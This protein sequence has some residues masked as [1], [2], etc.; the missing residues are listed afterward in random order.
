M[1]PLKKIPTWLII[2][3]LILLLIVIYNLYLVMS[4]KEGFVSNGGALNE[5]FD[6]SNA[7]IDASGI[8]LLPNHYYIKGSGK[9][10][11][12]EQ[13]SSSPMTNKLKKVIIFDRNVGVNST[14]Y[15]T[16]STDNTITDTMTKISVGYNQNN[17]TQQYNGYEIV[18]TA[19][20]SQTYDADSATMTG[21]TDLNQVFRFN[22]GYNTYIH[23][24]NLNT[25]NL[26]GN[27]AVLL[28][29][30]A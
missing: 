11:K 20:S 10:V 24:V 4:D 22:Y 29:Q 5:E 18:P 30:F 14:T 1:F 12:L 7:Y 25:I 16:D 15:S 21:S 26:R 3:L 27:L 9:I 17:K 8:K 19:N 6:L 23:T 28:P 13:D 2:I